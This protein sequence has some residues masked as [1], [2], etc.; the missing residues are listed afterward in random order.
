MCNRSVISLLVVSALACGR[1][2]TAHSG[3][4]DIAR[5]DVQ[6]AERDR[7]AEMRDARLW[8]EY[9]RDFTN[10]RFSPLDQIT[11]GNVN[12]LKL[13]WVNHSGIPHSSETNPIVIAGVMYFTTALNHVIALDA[14]TGGKKWEYA[15][16]YGGRTTADCCATNNKGP[17]VYGGR[18]YM[19]TIDARLVALDATNGRE[20]WRAQVGDNNK[21]YHMTGAPFVVDGRVIVGVS[22]G[23]QGCRCY[24]DAYDANDGHRLWRFYTVPSP[25]EGGWWGKWREQDEWGMSFH[26]DIA[27]EKADSAK[28]A[29]AWIHGGAPMWHHPAYDPATGLIY[30][31]VG[32]PA[33]DLEGA[34]RPG[35]NLYS[36]AIVAIDPRF[37]KLRWYYQE[38]AHDVWDYDATTPPVLVEVPDGSGRVV[39]AVAEAGKDG[40]VYVVDR[41]SGK[42]IRKSAAFVPFLN[43]MAVPESTGTVIAPGTLGGSDWSPTA[44]DPRTHY[45]FVDGS[46]QPFEYWVKHEELHEPAQWWGGTVAAAPSGAY[47]LVSA[48]DLGTG[49]IAWQTRF[50]KPMISGLLATAGGVVFTGSSDKHF[51]ALDAASGRQL[52]SFPTDAGVN[53]PPITYEIDGVQYVAV[54][55]TG[56]QTLNT[57]RGDEMLVFSLSTKPAQ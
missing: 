44:Y 50:P 40:F 28:Y 31:N 33:P 23:E 2:E 6:A 35:D 5:I 3:N 45:L 46:Y 49:K 8:P 27:K 21:G 25:E 42:P 37:G 34:I 54:A 43:Y 20:L 13:A 32:N 19:E 30:L 47:G 57:P 48:V 4:A 55:A 18:V 10:Q 51:V 7:L 24:V 1:G 56:L 16:D 29:D 11:A 36:D 9:G 22:G 41:L 15:Y 39:K 53:A 14:R 38:V 52:W 26:R 17:T 12:Q